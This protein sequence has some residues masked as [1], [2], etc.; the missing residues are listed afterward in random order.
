MAQL[1]ADNKAT[2]DLVHLVEQVPQQYTSTSKAKL[3]KII[4]SLVDILA[5]TGEHSAVIETV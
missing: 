5:A 2:A 1:L 3:S 4:R